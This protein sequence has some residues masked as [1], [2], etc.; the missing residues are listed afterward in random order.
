MHPRSFLALM[1]LILMLL[2]TLQGD[3]QSLNDRWKA[4]MQTCSGTPC[5]LIE[6]AVSSGAWTGPGS[7]NDLLLRAFDTCTGTPCLRVTGGSG[8]LIGDFSTDTTTSAAGEAV[9]F[10]DTTGKLGG[11]SL[12]VIAGP[13][14]TA[15]T[16]TFP[17]ASTTIL[18]TNAPVTVAQGGTG[19]ATLTGLALGSG[20]SAFSAY[21]GATCT[22]QFV[23]V[24]SA[25]G[26]ATC[27]TV[28][29]N[30]L[31]SSLTLTTPVIGNITPVGGVT[32]IAGAL[33]LSTST[34]TNFTTPVGSAV[35][36]KL[37][38]PLFTVPA[39][40][41][42]IAFGVNSAAA[43]SA[44]AMLMVDGR[45]VAHQPSFTLLSPSEA[46]GIGFTWDGSN[47]IGSVKSSVDF[48]VQV[49]QLTT[50]GV[51]VLRAVASGA[52][53]NTLHLSAGTLGIN[54]ASEAA[55]YRTT[56]GGS[57]LPV[58]VGLQTDTGARIGFASVNQ[59]NGDLYFIHA[60]D[61]ADNIA[62][63]LIRGNNTS[64]VTGAETGAII[65]YTKPAGGAVAEQF[66]LSSTGAVTLPGLG[67]A[68]GTPSSVCQNSVTK[69]VT[70]NAALT[71]TV[72]SKEQKDQI[73]PYAQIA[74]ELVEKIK[75]MAF[76]YR[77]NPKRLRWGFIAEELTEVHPLLADGYDEKGVAKS[78]D[79][80]ALLATLVKGMQ[81]QQATIRALQ[82][83]VTELQNRSR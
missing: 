19:V 1:S 42:V 21:P 60:N 47:A 67:T 43:T 61:T 76:V 68:S 6:A 20:T 3:T 5:V 17:N 35:P 80:N 81:E 30:D 83:Q 10:A 13:A 23:R 72:S 33:T 36:T 24:L 40:G 8:S 62:T 2:F 73:A 78:I 37:N 27:A 41:Q 12:F 70:V 79:Q 75:P 38:V 82:S 28:G 39:F 29:T 25:S 34:T 64:N 59:S 56:S 4:S 63:S 9:V 16:Y 45:T 65:M 49:G 74:L 22:N 44:R 48:D 51:S 14:T 7:V 71:C 66:R 55:F 46:E 18:T 11:R 54:T 57:A 53:A 15:K 77:D 32:D 58:R 69:E 52:T 50:A 31:A 26:A